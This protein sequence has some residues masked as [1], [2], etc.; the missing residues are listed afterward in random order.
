[1]KEKTTKRKE[2]KEKKIKI[3]QIKDFYSKNCYF[4]VFFNFFAHTA[5]EAV[6]NPEKMTVGR[7]R[8]KF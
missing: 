2:P 4:F 6:E 8:K 5:R 1:M 7:L 3:K